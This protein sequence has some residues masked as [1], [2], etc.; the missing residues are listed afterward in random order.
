MPLSGRFWYR[1]AAARMPAG[2]LRIRPEKRLA[3]IRGGHFPIQIG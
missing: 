2:P 3:E 1:K